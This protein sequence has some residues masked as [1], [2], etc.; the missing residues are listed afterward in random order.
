M[1]E[2]LETGKWLVEH[3]AT[4]VLAL[5]CVV[6]GFVI[7]HLYERITAMTKEHAM[8]VNTIQEARI[9]DMQA[10]TERAESLHDKGYKLAEDLGKA[11]E[12]IRERK[13]R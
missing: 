5:A 1:S 11:I 13:A 8:V 7:R 2:I 9:D 4:G 3:G 12:I 10:Y 6:E